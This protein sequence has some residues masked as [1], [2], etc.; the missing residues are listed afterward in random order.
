MKTY[1][2]L[3]LL[4]L[5][6]MPLES[7]AQA[8]G[9]WTAYPAMGDISYAVA[10]GDVIYALAGSSLYSV[11]TSDYSVTVYDKTKTLS[12]TEISYIEWCE[13]AKKL[14]IVY[15]DENIDLLS[16]DGKVEN[17]P[18]LYLKSVTG[19]KTVYSVDVYGSDA[20]IGTGFG[21]LKL[22][23]SAAEISSTYNL[24]MR[25]V[26]TH[27][28]DETIYAECYSAGRYS[29]SLEA[30][31][32]D[33]ASWTKISSS[34]TTRKWVTDEDL[35]SMAEQYKPNS[36]AVGYFAYMRLIGGRLFTVPGS[37]SSPE[38]PAAVQILDGDT[39]TVVEGD[40]GLEA[41]PSY[42]NLRAVDVDPTN[43]AR[44]LTA[45]A[46]GLY[47]YVGGKITQCWYWKNSILEL[48]A[49]VSS[50]NVNHTEIGAMRFDSGGNAWIVQAY[51]PTPGVICVAKDGQWTRY[52]HQEMMLP[53]GYSWTYPRNLDY[54]STGL[55]WFVNA[56]YTVPAL[57][58][59][60]AET[61]K[62]TAYTTFIN[63]DGSEI[64][65]IYMRCWAEDK[66]GNIWI[67]TD[68]GPAYLAAD[69]IK[70]GGETFF[71]PKIPREDDPTLADY[72]LS[73]VDV[74][75]IAVDAGNRKWMGTDGNGVYVISSDNM[76]QI[77]HFTSDETPLLSDN[78]ECIVIDDDS[79]LVYIATDKGLC[80][81]ASGVTGTRETLEKDDVYAYPNPVRPDY[82]GGVTVVG[83][84]YGAG[85]TITTA[86]G[87][88][89]KKGTSTGG[90]FSWDCT[91]EK[92]R[93]VASGVY[94][95][96]VSTEDG[97]SSLA[98]KIAVVR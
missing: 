58:S 8:A 86:S 27:I 84:T 4:L 43:S 20:Y 35:L 72:L 47:E 19:D 38:R 76:T 68:A 32:L 56:T 17:V 62:L 83:L 55:M 90:S 80:A 14:V 66:E 81:Y 79:G 61:D 40:T 3:P 54:S 95:V 10:G 36:P 15:S 69:D 12:D 31:L 64:N 59:Y 45:G 21:I 94:F 77:E 49:T 34:A 9:E 42:R 33:P 91:D 57:A 28:E 44:W 5:A 89:V 48:A 25:V 24:G 96:L 85:V 23:V 26:W 65:L 92:G 50:T 29:A 2:F 6:A 60:D 13:K 41:E 18:D 63:E 88:R 11:S 71:Q 70:S 73:G 53:A 22:D 82:E 78:I 39:W 37:S 16:L 98:T 97:K 93:R 75:C 46:P 1:R 67:G 30:N 74:T 7:P 87:Q 52:E 51:A